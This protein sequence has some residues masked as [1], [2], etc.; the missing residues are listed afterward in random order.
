MIFS[1]DNQRVY[2]DVFIDLL[3]QC[4]II[5]IKVIRIAMNLIIGMNGQSVK[6]VINDL[7]LS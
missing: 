1:L 6:S 2:T 3:N 4:G 7:K 5:A